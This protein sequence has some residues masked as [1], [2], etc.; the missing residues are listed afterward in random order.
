MGMK[1]RATVMIGLIAT[2]LAATKAGAT[3]PQVSVKRLISNGPH[4]PPINVPRTGGMPGPNCLPGG[5][6]Q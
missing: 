1:I 2:A 5:Q 3:Q 6:C 4:K